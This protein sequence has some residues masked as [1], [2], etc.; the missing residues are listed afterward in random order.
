MTPDLITQLHAARQSTL[1]LSDV[2]IETLPKDLVT[3]CI[4]Q[5][6]FIKKLGS[7]IKGWKVAGSGK[8]TPHRKTIGE[9]VHG[10]LLADR[11][12]TTPIDIEL[13]QFIAPKL[14]PEIA[15]RVA[16]SI[17]P[18]E[19]LPPVSALFDGV[20][21]GCDLADARFADPESAGFLAGIADLGSFGAYILGPKIADSA[22]N[23][24]GVEQ[25][26]LF[27]DDALASPKFGPDGLHDPIEI[28]VWLIKR[29]QQR[30]RGISAGELISTGT[31]APPIFATKSGVVSVRHGDAE[32]LS[33]NL[34]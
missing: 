3:A 31:L 24:E 13:N 5:D 23:F 20:F 34:I 28:S 9:P 17:G 25:I 19:E 26:E 14:E 22:A 16:V 10:P 7:D 33:F 2:N 29:L 21:L 27:V 32:E 1:K 4:L 12:F 30:G 15:L 18:D 6:E 11:F 8:D